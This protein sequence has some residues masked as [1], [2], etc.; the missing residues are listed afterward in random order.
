MHGKRGLCLTPCHFLS[1]P[2][3][4]PSPH[5]TFFQFLF[6]HQLHKN[7]DKC[8]AIHVWRPR[9]AKKLSIWLIDF[10][11]WVSLRPHVE[12]LIWGR[13]LSFEMRSP[14]QDQTEDG[15]GEWLRSLGAEASGSLEL[16]CRDWGGLWSWRLSSNP[17]RA[18]VGHVRRIGRPRSSWEAYWVQSPEAQHNRFVLTG[19]AALS[20]H[21]CWKHSGSNWWAI[22]WDVKF[23]VVKEDASNLGKGYLVYLN[24][25]G[26][27]IPKLYGL[28]MIDSLITLNMD[29]P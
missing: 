22:S 23:S 15:Q 19:P 25:E 24:S 14:E 10:H 27:A 29:F 2:S 20:S 5:P 6:S 11:S 1:F 3:C 9:D 28:R 4:P 12:Y 21:S 18:A 8:L 17:R 16:I 13:M 26:S 7:T